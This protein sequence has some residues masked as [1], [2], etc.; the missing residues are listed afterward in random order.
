MTQL[1][2]SGETNSTGTFTLSAAKAREK[3][4]KYS[5]PRPRLYVLN[6]VASATENGAT[7]IKVEANSS[8]L[9]FE[10]NGP[11]FSEKDLESILDQLL[12]PTE[13]RLFELGVALNALRSLQP[14]SVVMESWGPDSR[15]RLSL[16]GADYVRDTASWKT[17]ETEAPLNRLTINEGLQIARATKGLFTSLPE[18]QALE[19]L[20]SFAAAEVT[21]NGKNISQVVSLGTQSPTCLAWTHI[22]SQ[23][24]R[25]RVSEPSPDW[26]PEC[27]ILSAQ[28]NTRGNYE[29]VLVI[30]HSAASKQAC[31]VLIVNDGISFH[32]PAGLF[33]TPFAQVV[34][35]T[36]LSKNLSHT[37]LVE[38]E[39]YHRLKNSLQ[40]DLDDLFHQR[41]ESRLPLP[42]SQLS[43]L[44]S[45]SQSLEARLK[46]RGAHP[47]AA[48]VALWRK[49]T[50]FA[51]DALNEERWAELR[52]ELGQIE[53][54]S[55]RRADILR[56]S[57]ALAQAALGALE[58]SQFK[59]CHTCLERVR[60]LLHLQGQKSSELDTMRAIA[61][62][63]SSH[64]PAQ[65]F[66]L[67]KEIRA[68]VLLLQGHFQ[69]AASLP[70]PPPQA[71]LAIGEFELA[72]SMLRDQLAAEPTIEHLDALADCL[73]FSEMSN[74][75]RRQEAF[76]L[77]EKARAKHESVNI[78]WGNFLL[79]DLVQ[80]A[81]STL[82]WTRWLSY[83]M[84]AVRAGLIKSQ[85]AQDIEKDLEMASDRLKSGP[86]AIVRVKSSVL[87]AEKQ[88]AVEHPFLDAVRGRAA[89]C[90]RRAQYWGEAEQLLA[91]GR[92]LKRLL[93]YLKACASQEG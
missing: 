6:L 92:L 37:D 2:E 89:H 67:P 80:L 36:S 29:A 7:W 87:R 74:K 69:E 65:T 51:F 81:R 50:Q 5:L 4:A 25:L 75:K 43:H 13:L 55:L 71:L 48:R 49:E 82:P 90:L 38:D 34:V 14:K 86:A 61:K 41:L 59:A 16:S 35:A 66:H 18:S 53:T 79:D 63:L 23:T 46:G 30:D 9:T 26:C 3:L 93:A 42:S 47:A 22:R 12:N 72:E 19:T 64:S 15:A 17:P 32:R 33:D 85:L 88:L 24:P 57:Q 10:F 83:R 62:E 8:Q 91:R 1:Q 78:Q 77:K 60:E 11:S 44:L 40:C 84:N 58:A 73:A 20:A 68:E 70:S 52:E 31:D 56:V 21:L 27:L 45:W 76:Q 28:E 54:Q 39:A